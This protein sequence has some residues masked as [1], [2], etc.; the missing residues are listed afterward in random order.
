[1]ADN[2]F[3]T[4]AGLKPGAQLDSRFPVAFAEPVSQGY[5]LMTGYFS[6][7]GKSRIGPGAYDLLENI[8]VHL[9]CPVGGVFSLTFTRFNGKGYKV[10]EC[11]GIYSVT[12]NNGRWAIQL[13][14]TLFHEAGYEHDNY[15][16]AKMAHRIGSQGYLAHFGYRNEDV[17][18]DRS[19]GRGS[20]QPPLPT[21]T[22]VANVSFGYGPRERSGNARAGYS[23]EG[24]KTTGVASCLSVSEIAPPRSGGFNTRL[25]EFVDLAGGMVGQYDYTR[26]RPERPLLL[27]ATHDKA[28]VLGG[29]LAV[30]R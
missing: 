12:N 13:A 14:S 10:A 2:E 9:Y 28:H 15:P 7:K 22:R 18:N 11:E 26:L 17:L 29:L 8:D 20:Y 23:M 6:G 5:A 16:D 25:D 30:Y 27:H 24:W 1:M 3:A 19:V 4:P 21:G